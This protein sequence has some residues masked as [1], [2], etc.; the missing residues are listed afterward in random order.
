M[1]SLKRTKSI[2]KEC[3]FETGFSIFTLTTYVMDT[4]IGSYKQVS[5]SSIISQNTNITIL[6]ITIWLRNKNIKN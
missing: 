2:S 5:G 6:E 1:A 3:G 4:K